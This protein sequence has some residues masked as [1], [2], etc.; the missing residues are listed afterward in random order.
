VLV[1]DKHP[2]CGED[3]VYVCN[4]KPNEVDGIP[5]FMGFRH[6]RLGEIAYNIYGEVVDDPEYQPVFVP[7]K[8]LAYSCGMDMMMP[9]IVQQISL[10]AETDV[11]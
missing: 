6:F 10:K 9:T 4:V 5:R 7:K 1:Y 3:E 8:S 2:E 11:S